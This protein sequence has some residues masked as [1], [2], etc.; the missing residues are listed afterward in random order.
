MESFEYLDARHTH[1]CQ[2]MNATNS[3]HGHGTVSSLVMDLIEI[4]ATDSRTKRHAM[5]FA[6]WMAS[7]L[8]L[9]CTNLPST[10]SNCDQLRSL[11]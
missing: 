6:A 11:M 4:S 3:S 10:R 7:S 5:S 1:L 2:M 9:L 8:S